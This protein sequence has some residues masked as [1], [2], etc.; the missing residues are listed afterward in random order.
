[1]KKFL[2]TAALLF[3][4]VAVVCT[5]WLVGRSNTS[6]VAEAQVPL[7]AS[8][9]T[10]TSAGLPSGSP[11]APKP[12][13]SSNKTAGPSATTNQS[14]KGPAPA[15]KNS[16]QLAT[17]AQKVSK[18]V[19]PGTSVSMSTGV[20][21]NISALEAVQGVAQGPGE[22]AGPSLRLK[23]TIKN[24]TDKSIDTSNVV[25]NVNVGSDAVPAITL[26][27]PGVTGFP[28]SIPANT[29]SS[30]VYVF[31]VPLTLRNKVGI[32]VNYQVDSTIAAF[33]GAA[34]TTEGTP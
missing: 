5:V 3:V 10:A 21:A 31:L 23:V 34:P 17:V 26:S 18:P 33:E 12:S 4:V 8:A 19:K 30:A 9:G 13:P 20:E 2:I 16:V 11:A 24:S 25:V 32:F 15:A 14:K 22:V 28:D 7:S 6:S 29:S 27:G 1:M